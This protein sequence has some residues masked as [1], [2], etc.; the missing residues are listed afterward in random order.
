[1]SC[2]VLKKLKFAKDPDNY[3]RIVITAIVGTIVEKQMIMYSLP[4]LD[5]NQ[6][7]QQFGFTSG[8]SPIY[9]ALVLSEVMAEAANLNQ[10]LLI[11]PLDTSKALSVINHQKHPL[12]S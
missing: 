6:S 8:Y 2:P 3:H 7:C 11:T 10:E 12:H 5:H 4:I 1:M 9:A